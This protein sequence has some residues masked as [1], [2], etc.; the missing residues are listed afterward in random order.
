[1]KRFS[2]ENLTLGEHAALVTGNVVGR[3]VGGGGIVTVGGG[4]G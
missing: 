1:M 3:N 4:G 2:G